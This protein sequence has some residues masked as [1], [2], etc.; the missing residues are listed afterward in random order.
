MRCELTCGELSPN[1]QRY[2]DLGT[3]P[4]SPPPR[5]VA[6][7]RGTSTR[8][9]VQFSEVA[10]NAVF[11]CDDKAV[12]AVMD[13]LDASS[14]YCSPVETVP[15][16]SL[17]VPA[18]RDTPG[19]DAAAS[20][21][22][23]PASPE[24]SVDPPGDFTVDGSLAAQSASEA[25]VSVSGSGLGETSPMGP[26]LV[27]SDYELFATRLPGHLNSFLNPVKYQFNKF[28]L[29]VFSFLSLHSLFSLS[30]AVS[31]FPVFSS[32]FHRFRLFVHSVSYLQDRTFHHLFIV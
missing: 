11:N 27:D 14:E 9:E 1:F 19:V 23:S 18:L 28:F 15:V 20:G 4:R 10:V 31:I 17:S 6:V 13:S 2:L 30:S 16:A 22:C 32:I 3:A 21:F 24:S 12:Q 7:C 26:S 25:V 8:D 5:R 29:F